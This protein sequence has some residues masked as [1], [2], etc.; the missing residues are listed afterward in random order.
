[1]AT[2]NIGATTGN[3]DVT[4]HQLQDAHGADVGV[5]DRVL[6]LTHTPDNGGRLVLG[7]HLGNLQHFSFGNAGNVLDL[8]RR[9][10]H[11]LFLDLVDAMHASL[12]IFLVFPAVLED[13]IKHAPDEGNVGTG[14]NSRVDVGLG[15]RARKARIDDRHL[16]A[17]FLGVQ[18]VQHRH[19]MRFGGIGA[20]V[21][22]RLGKLHV[23]V[24]VGHR[25]ITPGIGDTGDRGRVADAGL[26]VHVVGTEEGHELAQQV[27]LLVALLR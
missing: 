27:S 4:E 23:V 2:E 11:H 19:R 3:T 12:Q 22:S 10:L 21:Q 6:G 18:H 24:G 16:A 1:V 17:V 20:D 14:T 26:V 5:T 8:V 7:Q 13:V 25:T 15:R 9:P